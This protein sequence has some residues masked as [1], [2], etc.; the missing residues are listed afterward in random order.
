LRKLAIFVEGQTEMIFLERLL[1]EIAGA[2]AI[3]FDKLKE[4]AKSIAVLTSTPLQV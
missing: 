3:V 4:V 2:H 1:I